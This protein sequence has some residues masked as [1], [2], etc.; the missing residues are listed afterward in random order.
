MSFR[1]GLCGLGFYIF[2]SVVVYLDYQEYLRGARSIFF[3]DKTE[4]EKQL[5]EMQR[6]E[7][8]RKLKELTEE[9]TDITEAGTQA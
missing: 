2:L 7:N 1:A 6:L 4:T 9:C 5:R 8:E 3:S